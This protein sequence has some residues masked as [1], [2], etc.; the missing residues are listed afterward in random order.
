MLRFSFAAIVSLVTLA[1]S[2]G[3][4][5]AQRLRGRLLDYATGEPIGAGAVTLVT[6]GGIERSVATTSDDGQWQIRVSEPGTFYLSA[7]RIGYQPWTS[8]AISVTPDD[9]L[10]F[11][12]HLRPVA[13]KLHPIEVTARAMRAYLERA[14]FYERQRADFGHF[15][16]PEA[17]EKRRAERVTDLLL[18]VPGVNLV[19]MSTGSVGALY[20]QLRG[21]TMSHGGVCR[22]RVFVDGVMFARGDSRPARPDNASV[23]QRV[24][25]RLQEL[26]QGMSL[27]DIGHPSAIAAIEVYRS[28]SQVPVQFGG[29]SIGT[30]CGA[31]VIWTKT[32]TRRAGQ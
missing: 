14:G 1:D 31:I 23:E 7:K 19:G 24:E 30:L 28:A 26:D 2:L 11:V 6:S 5:S 10:T 4:A 15:I 22:P 3:P 29:T 17:I 13:I 9:N 20:V 32:G 8:A 21:G 12:F 27:D 18:S 16:T 25:E